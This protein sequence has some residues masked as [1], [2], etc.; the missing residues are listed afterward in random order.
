MDNLYILSNSPG[1]VAGWVRPVAGAFADRKDE[2]R[3]TLVLLPCPYASGMEGRYGAEIRGIDRVVAFREF[4]GSKREGGRSLILQLGGDPAFGALLS[5]KFK[6]EWTLYSSRPRWKS[7]V[8]HYFVPDECS[9]RRFAAAKVAASRFTRV[10]H[11]ALDSVPRDLSEAEAKSRLGLGEADDAICFMP[12]SRPF[13]YE[14]GAAFFCHVAA[15]VQRAFPGLRVFMPIAPTVDEAV[16]T[17]GLKKYGL[18]WEGE[19]RAETAACG[20]YRI[21]LVRDDVFSAIKASKLVVA[22]PGTNNLQAAALGVPLLMAAPLN[23]AENI[24]LDG[25]AGMIP[26]SFPGFKRLKRKLVFRSNEKEKY[27]SLPNRLA[28]RA[29]VPEYRGLLT[30]EMVAERV[31]HLLSSPGSLE[32]IRRGYDQIK[33]EFGGA[34]KISARLEGYFRQ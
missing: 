15:E 14:Q 2:I 24:P 26:L 13:E 17:G 9:E 5:V 21:K 19:R 25:M 30:P 27:L 31:V 32:A 6:M 20:G 22:L 12:G 16:L 4:W 33:F 34:D 3:V 28:D 29:I 18:T 1:E 7:R 23:E 11:L 8:A 10:G